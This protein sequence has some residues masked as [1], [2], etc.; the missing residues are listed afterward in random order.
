MLRG[1]SLERVRVVLVGSRN[2]LNI[3][4]AARAMANFGFGRLRVVQP[5]DV[6]FREA[7]SAVGAKPVLEASEEFR[8]VGAAVADC[9]LVVGTTDGCRRRPEEPLERLDEGCERLRERIREGARIAVLF[10]SEKVGLSN[11]DLS[12]CDVLLRIPTGS[13]Q[14]SMNLGQAVAVV[15]YELA[16]AREPERGEPG[17]TE[18]P[19]ATAEDR[20]RVVEVLA[21]AVRRSGPEKGAKRGAE[22]RA[23]DGAVEERMRRLVRHLQLSRAEAQEWLGILR[24]IVWKLEHG[25]DSRVRSRVRG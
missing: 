19:R 9:E 20:E 15:L 2:P 14:P 10:G 17:L 7:R 23:D 13:E 12:H 11:R 1:E 18:E 4:A 3:G 22:E 16:G 5:Y 25:T 6:A 8:D 21:Q 24:R